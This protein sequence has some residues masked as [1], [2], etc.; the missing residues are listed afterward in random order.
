MKQL[1]LSIP[2]RDHSDFDNFYTAHNNAEAVAC[3]KRCASESNEQVVLVHGEPQS[4]R[5]HLLEAACAQAQRNDLTALYLPLRTLLESATAD[6]FDGLEAMPL[7]A[8]DDVDALAGHAEWE[9]ALF[10]LYN[11]GRQHGQCLLLTANAA[12]AHIP[13]GLKDLHSRLGAALVYKLYGLDE[14]GK[15]GCLVLR[16]ANLGLTVSDEVASYIL[17]RVNRDVGSLVSTVD[18]LNRESL[19]ESRRLTIPFVKKIMNW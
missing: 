19:S 2:L 11:R 5:S 7:L 18:T 1:P 4:G 8:L 10:H 17:L 6:V 3:L 16:G 12:P 13:Y 14:H 9:E 15:R